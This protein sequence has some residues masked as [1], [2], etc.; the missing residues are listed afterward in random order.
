MSRKQ[1]S[2]ARITKNSAQKIKLF[3]GILIGIIA[4]SYLSFNDYGIVRHFRIKREV[5]QI[6]AQIKMLE[7]QQKEINTRIEKLR[8][9]YDFIEKLARERL[10]LVKKGEELYIVKKSQH[11][12]QLQ[13]K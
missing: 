1:K 8:S 5:K 4:L 11:G 2:Q 13:K 7:Q 12:I 10:K 9:D 6:Q 3:C